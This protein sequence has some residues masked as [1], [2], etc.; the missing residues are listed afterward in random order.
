MLFC[1][2]FRII[3]RAPSERRLRRLIKTEGA[4]NKYVLPLLDLDELHIIEA[5]HLQFC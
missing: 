4:S 3:R 5:E 1:V 2:I